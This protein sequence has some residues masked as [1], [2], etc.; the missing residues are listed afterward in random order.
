MILSQ[1][2]IALTLLFALLPQALAGN[3]IV[4][5]KCHFNIWCAGAKNDRTATPAYKVRAGHK[6]TSPSPAHDDNVGAV[7]KCSL[8][9]DLSSPYQ[10]EVAVLEGRSFI[11]L[12]A[13]DGHPFLAYH[14]HAE[15]RKGGCIL[16]CPP[17]VQTCEWPEAVDCATAGDAIMTLC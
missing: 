5:N 13:L 14:R 8:A 2:I 11:D 7:L 15:V 3:L 10:L 6:F 1:P 4:H 16:D 9:S 12:S 17:G